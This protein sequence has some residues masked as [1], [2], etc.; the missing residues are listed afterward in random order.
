MLSPS[1]K[2]LS[3]VKLGFR[4]VKLLIRDRF[5]GEIENNLIYQNQLKRGAIPARIYRI[6]YVLL[7]LTLLKGHLLSVLVYKGFRWISPLSNT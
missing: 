4:E 7:R 2:Y 6:C 1:R 5:F 3:L